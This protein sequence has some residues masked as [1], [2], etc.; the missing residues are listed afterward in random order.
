MYVRGN[1]IWGIVRPRNVFGELSIV[2]KSIGP[3]SVEEMS[4]GEM[5]TRELS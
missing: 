4:V 3:I 2:E 1:V 5:S